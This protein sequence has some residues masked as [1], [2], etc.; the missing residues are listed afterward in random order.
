MAS[1]PD[2]TYCIPVVL[3]INKGPV[4]HSPAPQMPVPNEYRQNRI[5]Q[6]NPTNYYNGVIPN[7]YYIG[8]NSGTDYNCNSGS[9]FIGV[10]PIG[11]LARPGE[12]KHTNQ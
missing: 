1:H 10:C 11:P 12:F 7:N 9:E 2:H 4:P 8:A 6:V 3:H 5:Y